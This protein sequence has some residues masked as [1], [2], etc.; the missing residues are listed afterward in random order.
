ME[1]KELRAFALLR[2]VF[3]ITSREIHVLT[4]RAAT[5]GENFGKNRTN[6][7][8]DTLSTKC[9]TRVG[10]HEHNLLNREEVTVA[11]IVVERLTFVFV[12][13]EDFD[14]FVL[15]TYELVVIVDVVFANTIE[16]NV[17]AGSILRHFDQAAVLT[18][19]HKVVR[20][21]DTVLV[22]LGVLG[23]TI[24][25]APLVKVLYKLVVRH[26]SLHEVVSHKLVHGVVLIFEVALCHGAV[27]AFAMRLDGI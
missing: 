23:V 26:T 14:T 19:A 22:L 18:D 25:I 1:V 4:R 24:F 8:T 16:V 10:V 21:I 11:R 20:N 15:R 12:V 3:E 17:V 9:F 7:E 6:I 2:D 27:H 5:I 13:G